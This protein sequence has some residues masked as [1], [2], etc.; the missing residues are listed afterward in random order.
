MNLPILQQPDQ[1]WSVKALQ[2]VLR[3]Y[4]G[5]LAVDGDFGP[6]THAA[7][8]GFQQLAHVNADG[9]VGPITWSL[10]MTGKQQ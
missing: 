1:G 2:L 10:L 6:A 7:V 4:S 8:V 9:V 5:N 3:G